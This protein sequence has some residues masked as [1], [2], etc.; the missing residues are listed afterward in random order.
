MAMPSSVRKINPRAAAARTSYAASG[1]GGMTVRCA[2]PSDHTDRAFIMKASPSRGCASAG[3]A[4]GRQVWNS[5]LEAWRMRRPPPMCARR[6][7]RSS[8][9]L[10]VSAC[11]PHG[12]HRS[13]SGA[14]LD[15]P[16]PRRLHVFSETSPRSRCIRR[17][18]YAMLAHLGVFGVFSRTTPQHRNRV[19]A[20]ATRLRDSPSRSILP[21][22][23]ATRSAGRPGDRASDTTPERI[24]PISAA[25]YDHQPR[26][27]GQSADFRSRSSWHRPVE[28]DPVSAA[29]VRVLP[30]PPESH[31]IAPQATSD[32]VQR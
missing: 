12:R 17:P 24:A 32:A 1:S 29:R 11:A 20:N 26:G 6:P 5:V 21:P 3:R 23:L 9:A 4:P 13:S 10:V 2:F 18:R 25:A 7:A 16:P 19:S 28:V 15:R 30:S 22:G 14:A 8:S 27:M 31:R